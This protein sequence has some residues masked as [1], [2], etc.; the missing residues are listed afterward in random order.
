MRTILLNV[1]LAVTLLLCA[2]GGNGADCTDSL[3][4]EVDNQ[5]GMNER[6][7][8][9]AEMREFL[10]NHW[11]EKKCGNLLFTGVSKEGKTSYSE[12]KITL[13]RPST[14]VLRV[15]VVRDRIGHLG[16][17]I[18]RT[19]ANGAY[20]A[21]TIERIITQNPH[22]DWKTKVIVLGDDQAVPPLKYWL[23]FKDWEGYPIT[24]F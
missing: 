18:P 3:S 17:V 16:K 11:R 22:K 15:T 12:F 23:R 6:Q 14:M 7:V 13:I 21:Y 19:D 8:R 10:W 4:V 20:E 9:F 2:G 5:A 1:A 24:Y